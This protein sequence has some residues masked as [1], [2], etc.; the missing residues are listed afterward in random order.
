VVRVSDDGG[1]DVLSFG[2]GPTPTRV[3]I[4][5]VALAAATGLIALALRAGPSHPD[6]RRPTPHPTPV[7]ATPSPAADDQYLI[8]VPATDMA[9]A[10]AAPRC[11]SGCVAFNLTTAQLHRAAASFAGLH[12]LAGGLVRGSDHGVLQQSVEA[13][14]APDALVHLMTE[15]IGSRASTPPRVRDA[16]GDGYDTITVAR[17]RSGWRLTATI[18]VRGTAPPVAAA[19]TW[20]D[21]TPLPN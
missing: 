10:L 14:A 7:T 2:A 3:A 13:L 4:V 16:P 6:A 15:R 12:P 18:V 17:D 5:T 8:E 9:L 19:R 20:A 1:E 21:T 11:R